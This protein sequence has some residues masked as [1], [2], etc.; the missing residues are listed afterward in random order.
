MHLVDGRLRRV[1]RDGVVGAPAGVLEDYGCVAAGFLDLAPGHRRPGLARRAPRRCSTRRSTHFRADDGGFF[2]TADDAEALVAR[3]RDPTDNAT[4]VGL[5]AMVHALTTY[6][7]LTGEGRHRDA[8]EE[9]LATVRQLAERAPR[10]AGWSLAAAQA[11][12]DGPAGGRGRRPAR[13]ERDALAARA[14]AHPGAVV[15]VAD[16]PLDGIPLLAGR[17]P[18]DGRAGG[19]RLPWLR[20]RAAGHR[21]SG[22]GR[23]TDCDTLTRVGSHP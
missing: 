10:F 5:S 15:V 4:P 13:A 6:A 14:R 12:L 20:V 23:G 21:R 9:A 11:M 1:S 18:V 7:A 19:V 17:T 8:A 3:P 22:P 2:D 16:G